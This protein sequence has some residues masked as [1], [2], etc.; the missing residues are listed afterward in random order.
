MSVSKVH[1]MKMTR[2]EPIDRTKN[3]LKALFKKAGLDEILSPGEFVAI[4]AHFGEKGN[5][6]YLDPR[7][8]EPIVRMIK[9]RGAKPFVTDTCVLYSGARDNAIDHLLI[10]NEHGYNIETLGAPVIIADGILG[11]NETEIEVNAPI[12]P[13]VAVAAE[14]VSANSI[15][16]VSHATGHITVGLAATLKNLGMGMASRKGKLTQ[17]SVSKPIISPQKCVAC[18]TCAGSCPVQAITVG[19]KYAVI[20]ES[21]CIGC[22]ECLTVCRYK[23]VKFK[24]NSTTEELQKRI[25]E[26][27][28][29]IIKQKN[30]KIGYITFLISMSQDC[31]CLNEKSAIMLDDIGVLAGKDPVAIDQAVFDLTKQHAGQSLSELAFP[32]IDATVQLAYAEQ[33]GLGSRKYH[34]I[35]EEI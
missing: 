19:E 14:L 25:V 8:I 11:K 31:D 3:R 21:I 20:D 23:A 35:E 4:K 9:A 16:V 22:G 27:A 6:T 18:G 2:G 28:L 30:G 24:W 33:L 12:Y 5:V 13:K 32:E 17:H 15:I 10:A 1:F 7:Y 29:G 34:L 26:H